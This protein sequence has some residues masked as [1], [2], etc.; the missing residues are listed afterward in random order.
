MLIG[1]T[2]Y[3]PE[4]EENLLRTYLRHAPDGLILTGID[5]TP[6]VWDRCAP[7]RFPP[8]TPSRRWTTA[9]T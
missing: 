4:A 7:G 5:H 8:S 6:G 1:V 3:S 9:R 2:G